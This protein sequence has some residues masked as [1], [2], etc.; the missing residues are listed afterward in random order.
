MDLSLMIKQQLVFTLLLQP[1]LYGD[2]QKPRG[3]LTANL[4]ILLTFNR[5]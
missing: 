1:Q 2:P 5:T 3:T 4:R